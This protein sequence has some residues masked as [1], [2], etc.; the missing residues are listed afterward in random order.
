M[1]KKETLN[2]GPLKNIKV[3]DLTTVVM[4]PSATQCLGDLGAE[5]IKVEHPSGDSMRLIGPFKNDG[6]GPLFLLANRNKKSITLDLKKQEHK[7]LLI[8]L[9]SKVDVVVSNI[10]PSA[11]ER[12]GISYESISKVNS[13]IIFCSA[14]GYGSAGPLAGNAVYD[15]LMQ[16]ASGI[17]GL[18]RAIDGRPRYA[19]INI[20]DRIVGLYVVI[21]ITSAL[22]HLNQTGEGQ[23]IEVPMYETMTQF[24]L[25]DHMGG[26]VFSPP[27]GSMGYKRL[28]S[29]TRGPYPTL[30][31]DL[32]I[33]VYT[34]A[35]WKAFLKIVDDEGLMEKDPR[36]VSQESRTQNAIDIGKYLADKLKSKSNFEWLKIL[37]EADI[38]ASPVNS[39][40]DLLSDKHLEDVNFFQ[41]ISHPTEGNLKVPKFPIQFS[42]SPASMRLHPPA[43]GENN[44]EFNV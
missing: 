10:R 12:L 36:F 3:L 8:E 7:K 5:I 42:K 6:M 23:E 29:T 11:L 37:K 22:H 44:L 26:A 43:I 27:I 13:K 35:H 4:G 15:D 30:D 28:L 20:C 34:N 41:H 38:P 14:V 40:E 31:G 17:S 9:A 2:N 33:V 24:V 21:A 16:A 25:S 32:S 1:N 18:F 19:P 39:I